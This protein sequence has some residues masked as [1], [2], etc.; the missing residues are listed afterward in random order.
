MAGPPLLLSVI[1]PFDSPI[2]AADDLK[3][4]RIGVST[5]NSLT[6]WL[7][8]EL[9]HQKRW[10][11]DSLT[12]V[13]V[14]AELPNQVAALVTHQID[15]LVSSTALGLTLTEE[16]RGRILLPASDVVSQF[17]IHTIYASAPM[18]EKNPNAVRGFLQGWFETIAFMR[19]HRDETV[20]ASKMRTNF[21][22]AV[23]ERQYDLV[24]P[25]FSST[26]RFEPQALATIQRSFADLKLIDKE[27]D[28]AKYCTERFLPP[29]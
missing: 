9:A 28:L 20:Q 24:M 16:K 21:S 5:V 13:T 22:S 15:A 17:M 3:G 23:E 18:A 6:Q 14:G 12:Y 25:M 26:G 1:V 8:R 7:M 29:S 27:G 11:A 2:A 4:K 10:P 19:A